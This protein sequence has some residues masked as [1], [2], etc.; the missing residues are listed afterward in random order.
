MADAV[1]DLWKDIF[2]F[3]LYWPAQILISPKY[4]RMLSYFYITTTLMGFAFSIFLEIYLL[5][6]RGTSTAHIPR[7]IL[8]QIQN[9]VYVLIPYLSYYYCKDLIVNKSIRRLFQETVEYDKYCR[10]KY[11]AVCRL[12]LSLLV[13]SV[14][15]Y[16]VSVP[17]SPPLICFALLISFS[18][19]SPFCWAFSFNICIMDAFRMRALQFSSE[20]G[21]FGQ[22]SDSEVELMGAETL[23]LLVSTPATTTAGGNHLD[24]RGTDLRE[25]LISSDREIFLEEGLLHSA[26]VMQ[27]EII[28]PLQ[29]GLDSSSSVT[30]NVE[31]KESEKERS[32]LPNQ[33]DQRLPRD[34]MSAG[35]GAGSVK[36]PLPASRIR[37]RYLSY[38]K[39]CLEFSQRCGK[40]LLILFTSALIF[41]I[42]TVWG[43][44]LDHDNTISTFPF[45]MISLGLVA[46]LGL[47]IAGANEAGSLLCRNISNHLLRLNLSTESISPDQS[48]C[49][50]QSPND[51]EHKE[52]MLLLQ[53]MQYS[54]IQIPFF[55]EFS[56]R[57]K[58]ILT[59][60]GSIIGAIIPAIFLRG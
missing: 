9:V 43:I 59:I 35:T 23:P 47:S 32:L 1:M 34:T 15:I 10:L 24:R 39:D 17:L 13:F 27:S 4:V 60:L 57:S 54:K 51:L 55:G 44:Y 19:F 8:L 40:F 36:M 22:D 11:R 30:E 48:H 42:A 38:A 46:Q 2:P 45:V 21:F 25:K 41:A 28:S 58:T 3:E 53:C 56:L 5:V 50:G 31:K 49:E 52:A 37:Q 20:V 29:L 16:L 7:V 12:N 26:P 6:S 14:L 18:Y 33:R